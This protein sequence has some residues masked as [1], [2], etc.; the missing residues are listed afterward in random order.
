MVIYDNNISHQ[1]HQA[2]IEGL[3]SYRPLWPTATYRKNK[4]Y[5]DSKIQY[6]MRV[7]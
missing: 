3:T 1:F 5:T 2:T 7:E 6:E 4:I